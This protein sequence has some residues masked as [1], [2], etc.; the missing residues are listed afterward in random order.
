MIKCCVSLQK[1]TLEVQQHQDL[2]KILQQIN[3]IVGVEEVTPELCG[4]C[5]AGAVG[6]SPKIMLCVW[7]DVFLHGKLEI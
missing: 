6:I 7:R 3:S 1:I 5:T 4:T 2:Q